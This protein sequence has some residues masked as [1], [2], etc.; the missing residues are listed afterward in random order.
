MAI[1][2]IY[3]ARSTDM[4]DLSCCAAAD[5]CALLATLA[6]ACAFAASN[7]W[8][9]SQPSACSAEWTSCARPYLQACCCAGHQWG[10]RAL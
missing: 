2:D 5:F 1:R 8:T 4:L 7:S 9:S 6:R 10:G 3:K